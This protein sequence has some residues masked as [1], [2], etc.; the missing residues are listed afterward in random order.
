MTFDTST[1][2]ANFKNQ[3]WKIGERAGKGLFKLCM[4][5]VQVESACVASEFKDVKMS[6]SYLWHLRLGHI[7]H[8]GLNAIVKQKLGV[9]I[10]IATVSKWELCNRCALGGSRG[11]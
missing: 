1:F 11:G 10:D 4:V 3:K 9:G 7:G 6:K 8:D 2:Y 5:P